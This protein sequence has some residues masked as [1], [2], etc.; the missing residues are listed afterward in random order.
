MHKKLLVL[1]ILLLII[2]NVNISFA[3][4]DT[5]NHW[6]EKQINNFS[7]NGIISG[8]LDNTFRPNNNMTRAELVSVINRL[9]SN[10]VQSTKYVPDIN[11]K[12]W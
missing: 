8:Y 6:A 11:S 10:K 9:L 5:Q 2:F 12:D 1:L 4:T 7:V 3:Y